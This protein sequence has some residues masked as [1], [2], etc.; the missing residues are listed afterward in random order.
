MKTE[1]TSNW[2]TSSCAPTR[3][4]P[5]HHSKIFYFIYSVPPYRSFNINLTCAPPRDF[6]RLFSIIQNLF[7]FHIWRCGKLFYGG[8]RRA[9]HQN[10]R[11]SRWKTRKTSQNKYPPRMIMRGYFFFG[12]SPNITGYAQVRCLHCLPCNCYLPPANEFQLRKPSPTGK[13]LRRA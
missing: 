5:S 12:H 3:A 10:R 9:F 7:V 2:G 11:P 13:T 1:T 4:Y 8:K 6:G